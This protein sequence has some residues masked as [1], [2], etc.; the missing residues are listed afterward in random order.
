M[1]LAAALLAALLQGTPPAPSGA[2]PAPSP[3][4]IASPTVAPALSAQPA[5]ADHLYP[6]NVLRITI[7]G[8]NGAVTAAIDNP[9][10]TWSVDQAAHVL[11]LTAGQTLGRAT[12]TVTDATNQSITVPVRVGLDAGTIAAQSL[13]L[14]YT[15]NPVDQAWLQKTVQKALLQNVQSAPGA[16][17]QTSFALPSA[18]APGSIGAFDAQVQITGGDQYYP[19]NSVVN[20]NL[21]N[22][23][24]ES[25]APSLLLYDDD[26]EHITT[27]GVLYRGRVSPGQPARLYY[28]HDNNNQPHDLVVAFSAPAGSATV[29]LIDV[30]RGPNIDVMTVGHFVTR[31]FL[32]QK[33]ANQGII[34]TVDPQ[35]PYVAERFPLTS[36]AGAAGTVD[37]RVV[38]GGPVDVT[39]LSVAPETPDASIPSLLAQAKLPGDGH[40]R[41]GVFNVAGYAHEALSY[42]V[43]G[44]DASLNYGLQSPPVVEPPEGRDFGEYGV[45]RTIDFTV[46]NATG[47]PATIYLYE[48]PMGGPLRSSFVINGALPPIDVGC[49]RLSQRYQIG[50][51]LTVQPGQSNI[52]LQTMTDGGSNY[53]LEVGLTVTPPIPSAP[54]I[55]AP[56]G[57][58]PKTQS[59]PSPASPTPAPEPTGR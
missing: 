10:A 9:I 22:V 50:Q 25:F 18:L 46:N 28:Y 57:C 4:P 14:R 32:V 16:N 13:S 33:P 29:Q 52:Q 34:V 27:E 58:F 55:T 17:P 23:P 43:G 7:A 45:W 44:E 49:V 54:P 11:T 37:V 56:D 35:S 24:T 19:V 3:S 8:A 42:T 31:D 20:V 6:G 12:L 41:T 26:P 59:S 21:Q 48:S 15:G 2:S 40:H 1:Q 47:Q 5:A 36:L 38:S 51:P 39:V 53:P 30:S